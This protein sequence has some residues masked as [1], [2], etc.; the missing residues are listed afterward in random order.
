MNANWHLKTLSKGGGFLQ[1]ARGDIT[2]L[3]AKMFCPKISFSSLR[4]L[5]KSTSWEFSAEHIRTFEVRITHAAG[6]DLGLPTSL[7]LHAGFANNVVTKVKPLLKLKRLKSLFD[8]EDTS[9]WNRTCQS[10]EYWLL[11]ILTL[12]FNIFP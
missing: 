12:T 4:P 6:S 8:A 3:T 11:L 7:A 9:G 1:Q 5:A 10:L 2:T